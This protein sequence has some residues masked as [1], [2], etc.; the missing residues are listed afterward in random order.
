MRI[1]RC[2][3]HRVGHQFNTARFATLTCPGTPCPPQPQDTPLPI[4]YGQTISAPH[5]HA[6]CLEILS[7]RLHPGARALD[8]G[9]GTA[10]G[11]VLLT[12]TQCW[13]SL[14][15]FTAVGTAGD[16]M[17][18]AM[19]DPTSVCVATDEGQRVLRVDPGGHAIKDGQQIHA[20]GVIGVGGSVAG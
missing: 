10:A 1:C 20:I 17:M 2:S 9:S 6:H 16:E 14:V 18:T 13:Y 4:G 5:M 7:D 3:N 11:A 15:A 19:V 12:G 8:V